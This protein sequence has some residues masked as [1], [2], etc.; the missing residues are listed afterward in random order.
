WHPVLPVLSRLS[1]LKVQRAVQS[2]VLG[3][4]DPEAADLLQ[5]PLGA[6]TAECRC[7]VTDDRGIV[8]YVAEIIYR[9]DCIR[10]DIDLLAGT[11]QSQTAPQKSPPAKSLSAKS[12]RPTPA[13]R[14]KRTNAASPGKGKIT[15]DRSRI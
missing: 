6:P 8:V 12:P 10:L 1:G 2:V 9:S 13:Q 7:V 15:E 11:T 5:V 3:S 4:A 14:R